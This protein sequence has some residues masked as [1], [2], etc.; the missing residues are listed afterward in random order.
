MTCRHHKKNRNAHAGEFCRQTHRCAFWTALCA[1]NVLTM[2]PLSQ[3]SSLAEQRRRRARKVRCCAAGNAAALGK[4]AA[5]RPGTPPRSERLLLCGRERRRARKDCCCA[6]GNA[7]A[8]GKIAAVRP[9]TPPRSERLLL[10][11][12]ERR[13]AEQS[14]NICFMEGAL[15]QKSASSVCKEAS[16]LGNRPLPVCKEASRLGNRPL[17]VCKEASRLGNRPFRISRR[18]PGS[19]IGLSGFPEGVPARQSA[20]PDFRKASRL[21]NRPFRISGRRPGSAIGLS[22]FPE[23]VLPTRTAFVVTDNFSSAIVGQRFDNQVGKGASLVARTRLPKQMYVWRG[24]MSD[25]SKQM[26]NRIAWARYVLASARVHGA[27]IASQLIQEYAE[28]AENGDA[29]DAA[30]M[31]TTLHLLTRRLEK[32]T[33]QMEGAELA[34]S[35]ELAD[36]NSVREARDGFLETGRS[37]YYEARDLVHR[38]FGEQAVDSYALAATPPTTADGL[39]AALKNTINLMEAQPQT[40]RDS[41]GNSYETSAVVAALRP[42]ADSLGGVLE[43]V[44]TEIREVDEARAHRDKIVAEWLHIFRGT[45]AAL[46]AL[47]DLAGRHDLAERIRPT[48]ARAEGETEPPSEPVGDEEPVG[49]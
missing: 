22:G 45:A 11:G 20:F 40:G 1:K 36:D 43:E 10:C 28:F 3:V 14:T 13:R 16:R 15:A 21:G 32:K 47:Y 6:A 18:R 41:F 48:L 49:A 37:Q 8:L 33:D 27:A 24:I 7:A 25:L 35:A 9:G 30:A 38:A 39:A 2:V 19:A 12:R 17:P 4:I 34:V 23:G 44:D 5:V 29:H 26:S 46:S 31:D 42:T